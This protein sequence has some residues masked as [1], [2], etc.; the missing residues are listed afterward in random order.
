[1][2]I[3]PPLP[4][5][6][7]TVQ[8]QPW[9]RPQPQVG[10]QR[11][12]YALPR[13]RK[14]L[15]GLRER[16]LAYRSAVARRAKAERR[17]A[18]PPLPP[19]TR[20]VGQLVAE[21]VRFY[22]AHFWR[23]LALGLGPA[24]VTVAG[25]EVGRRAALGVVAGGWLLLVTA[26]YVGACALVAERP[27]RSAGV[28][29]A[30]LAGLLV[31]IPAPLLSSLALLP[32]VAW[33]AFLGLAVPAAVV[34]GLGVRPALSRGAALGRVDYIHAFGS[35]CALAL[36]VFLTQV[37]LFALLHG[38]SKQANAV[39]GFLASLVISPILF[40]GAALLYFDQAARAVSSR[41]RPKRR[42]DADVSHAHNAH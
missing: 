30:Y 18:P 38:A 28:R 2:E 32:A 21:T 22:G 24:V 8:W 1:V 23:S 20:T 19:E 4:S 17:P 42:R 25:Y 9:F 3:P 29:N 14:L 12:S 6:Q 11:S 33:L 13:G 27:L 10:P 39:A 36:V 15:A 41:P 40:V 37:L 5:G 31:A 16:K 35:L 34:E 7:L 26:S